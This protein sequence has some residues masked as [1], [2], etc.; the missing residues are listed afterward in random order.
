MSVSQVASR[1]A[2][3]L[4]DLAM[5]QGKT[6]VVKGDMATFKEAL[7]SRDLYL[8]LKSP[9]IYPAKKISALKAVFEGKLDSLTMAFFNLTIQ[10][11][12]ESL[13]VD[14]ADEFFE[15]YNHQFNIALV[16]VTSAT[17]LDQPT[18]DKILDKV[19]SLVGSDKTIQL[20]TVVNPDIIGGFIIQYD[21]KLYDSSVAYQLSKLKQSFLQHS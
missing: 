12:R 20:E 1:Y 14:I 6:E 4:L 13:L 5:E 3:S 9:I 8:L 11:G 2:K 7:K 21:D 17:T 16:K 10:K 18:I 19:K 15:Q